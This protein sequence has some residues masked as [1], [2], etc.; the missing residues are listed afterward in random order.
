[1]N[2]LSLIVPTYNRVIYLDQILRFVEVSKFKY[3]REIIVVDSDSNDGTS[4]L[5]ENYK[6]NFPIDIIYKNV[7]NSISIKRNVGIKLSSSDFLIF[8]DDDCIP[9]KNFF[10]YHYEACSRYEK[11][12]NCGNIFFEKKSTQNSN[13][14]NYR[15]SRHIPFL[16]LDGEMKELGFQHIVT[17]NMSLRKKDLIQNKLLFDEDFVAYGMEDNYFGLEAIKKGFKIYTNQASII[18][19]DYKG[20]SLHLKKL[21]LTSKNG[22]KIFKF[23]DYDSSFKLSYSYFLEH[24]YKHKNIIESFFT[25]IIRNLLFV[26]VSYLLIIFLNF[27]DKYS[28][29]YFRFI[30]RY[31]SATFYYRGIKDRHDPKKNM[32]LNISNWYNI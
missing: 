11:S 31:V 14:I 15:N 5:I 29:L 16:N 8:L 10:H 30:Y 6:K 4:R 20:I 27:T 2:T 7:K 21:Y 12:I 9:Q 1:M 32:K 23:K 25:C 22:V 26:K 17:M 3:L 28:S 13:F 19:Y 24:D 18:H